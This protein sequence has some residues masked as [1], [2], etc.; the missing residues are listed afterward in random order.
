[1]CFEETIGP[2]LLQEALGSLSIP[3]GHKEKLSALLVTLGRAK[4]DGCGQTLLVA[5]KLEMGMTRHIWAVCY[6]PGDWRPSGSKFFL[7]GTKGLFRIQSLYWFRD[8]KRGKTANR[9]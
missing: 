6:S 1:M 2:S 7:S 4:A 9:S 8:L 3:K 5:Q